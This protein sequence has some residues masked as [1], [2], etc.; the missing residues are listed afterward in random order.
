MKK[1]QINELSLRLEQSSNRV[2]GIMD[3]DLPEKTIEDSLASELQHIISGFADAGSI[4]MVYNTCKFITDTCE[5]E[6]MK[7]HK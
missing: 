7:Q 3:F 4:T 1:E 2:L 6:L 5:R